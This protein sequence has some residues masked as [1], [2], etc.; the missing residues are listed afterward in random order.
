M[1]S[2]ISL[3]MTYLLYSLIDIEVLISDQL[4]TDKVI[5]FTFQQGIGCR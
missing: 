4:D 3:I 1:L 5:F 2:M